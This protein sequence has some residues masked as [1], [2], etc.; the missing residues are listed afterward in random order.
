MYFCVIMSFFKIVYEAM[1]NHCLKCI[2]SRN[3]WS[4]QR[5]RKRLKQRLEELKKDSAATS[6]ELSGDSSQREDREKPVTENEL[7]QELERM[8]IPCSI[9]F[10]CCISIEEYSSMDKTA[11][12]AVSRRKLN[13]TDSSVSSSD[14]C[15][16]LSMEWLEGSDRDHLHQILQYF[17]NNITA[18]IDYSMGSYPHS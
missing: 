2:A 1:P 7:L 4:H 16:V 10:S 14:G 12:G 11:I 15:V 3:T 13:D 17:Q 9:V 5:K 8:S 18:W 6:N